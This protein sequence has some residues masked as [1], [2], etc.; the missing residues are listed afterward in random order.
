MYK[1]SA[2]TFFFGLKTITSNFPARSDILPSRQHFAIRLTSSLGPVFG[3]DDLVFVKMDLVRF[4]N[5]SAFLNNT[6]ESFATA[7]TGKAEFQPNDVE[8]LYM[9][10]TLLVI[11][12]QR[13]NLLLSRKQVLWMI[14]RSSLGFFS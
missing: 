4:G 13:R 9:G 1:T 7:A 3:A 6:H 14:I 2:N 5:G 10:G 12:Y 11:N 8:V